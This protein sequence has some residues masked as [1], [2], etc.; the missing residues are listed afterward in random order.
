MWLRV[1]DETE[2]E[3]AALAVNNGCELNCGTA[4][5]S[6]KTAVAMGLISEETITNAVEKLFEA[7]FRL[8]MFDDDCE[9]DK[10]PYDVVECDKHT[11]I[12]RKMAQECTVLLK[13]NG[14][15]PISKDVKTIAVIGPNADDFGVLKGNFH[16][17]ITIKNIKVN[18][19]LE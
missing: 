13:N 18:G 15:L 10:I 3:S 2:A 11:A 12:N 16:F 4:Y 6:L 1:N 17:V 8:G 14:I 7:R 9:Y 5:G 19:F